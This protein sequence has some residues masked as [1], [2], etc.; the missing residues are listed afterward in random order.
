MTPLEFFIAGF[1]LGVFIT[2][3]CGAFTRRKTEKPP[4]SSK[5][6]EQLGSATMNAPDQLAKIGRETGAEIIDD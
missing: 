1:L 5:P 6:T 3:C 4:E 2:L